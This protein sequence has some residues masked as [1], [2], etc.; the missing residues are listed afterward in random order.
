M[1]VT[2]SSRT[3]RVPDLFAGILSGESVQNPDESKV[4]AESE[5]W[6]KKCVC[7]QKTVQDNQTQPTTNLF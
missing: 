7:A 2:Q 1:T 3:L 6:C 5:A 4:A